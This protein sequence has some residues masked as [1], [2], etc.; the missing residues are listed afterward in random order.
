[1]TTLFFSEPL[2]ATMAFSYVGFAIQIITAA[3]GA[4]AMYQQ[5]KANA[6]IADMNANLA[7]QEAKQQLAIGQ[8]QQQLEERQAE[9]QKQYALAEASAANA[10]AQA[11]DNERLAS[12]ARSREEIR[13]KRT[14]A[15]RLL[16][17]QSSGYSAA[18]VVTTTGTPL[19]VMASTVLTEESKAIDSQYL[20]N[21]ESAK[22]TWSAQLERARAGRI[23]GTAQ[24]QYALDIQASKVRGLAAQIGARNKMT[25]ADIERVAGRLARRNANFAAAG[26]F[27]GGI[28]GGVSLH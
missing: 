16:A 5:G 12:E 21:I 2:L 19:A 1:M 7:N 14:E 10:N 25:Q 15:E 28:A 18:G 17:E 22:S 8:I 24:A 6:R 20:T 3:V 4:V 23:E 9:I 27:L 13:R 11:T 26:Q